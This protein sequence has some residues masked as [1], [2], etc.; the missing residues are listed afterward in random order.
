MILINSTVAMG[1]SLRTFPIMVAFIKETNEPVYVHWVNKD[2]GELF[3]L[4]QH[5]GHRMDELPIDSQQRVVNI[6]WH[7]YTLGKTH[8]QGGLDFSAAVSAGFGVNLEAAY[9][10]ELGTS[11]L[12][13][14]YS[15][16]PDIPE[17]DFIIAPFALNNFEKNLPPHFWQELINK[18]KE[19]YEGCSICVIGK[20]APIPDALLNKIEYDIGK[21]KTDEFRKWNQTK[22]L[23]GVDYFVDQPLLKVA[24]LL[25]KMKKCFICIDSGPTH[26]NNMIGRPCIE[27]YTWAAITKHSKNPEA[28]KREELAVNVENTMQKIDEVIR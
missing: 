2:V 15:D 14:N 8:L 23:T 22:Y 12:D 25:R 7:D 24:T 16:D 13:Y 4:E 3:P 19:K 26:L 28:N 10:M 11:S 5:G 27:L 6:S 21:W 17:Y 9:R 20:M 18:L 1:D